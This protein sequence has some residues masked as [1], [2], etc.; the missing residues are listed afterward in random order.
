MNTTSLTGHAGHPGHYKP[1]PLYESKSA[2]YRGG[3]PSHALQYPGD[4][5]G[6]RDSLV[7]SHGPMYGHGRTRDPR[8]GIGSYRSPDR[9]DGLGNYYRPTDTIGNYSSSGAT[10][11]VHG[12]A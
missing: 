4:A 1:I 11:K 9:N 6:S 7:G 3:Y 5:D 12:M 2:R 8:G 10:P